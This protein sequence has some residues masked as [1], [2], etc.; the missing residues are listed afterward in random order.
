MTD[1]EQCFP[2]LTAGSSTSGSRLEYSNIS[3]RVTTR[4]RRRYCTTI[5]KRDGNIFRALDL[6]LVSVTTTRQI[7][8]SREVYVAVR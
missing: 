6:I 3:A 2:D 4:Q 8:S 7:A 1:L 5:I